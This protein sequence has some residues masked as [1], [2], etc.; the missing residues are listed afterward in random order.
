MVLGVILE[1]FWGRL[2]EELEKQ[3]SGFRLHRRGRIACRAFQKASLSR[4]FGMFGKPSHL[5]FP[6]HVTEESSAK[7]R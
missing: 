3:K 6:L 1:S 2:G 7:L 4:L 5:G